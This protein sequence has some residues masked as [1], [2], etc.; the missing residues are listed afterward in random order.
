MAKAEE[1]LLQHLVKDSVRLE[2]EQNNDCYVFLGSINREDNE[3]LEI[4][5][6]QYVADILDAANTEIA[7][8]MLTANFLSNVDTRITSS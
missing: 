6:F 3:P 8:L 2:M 4:T 5:K 1:L 7:T